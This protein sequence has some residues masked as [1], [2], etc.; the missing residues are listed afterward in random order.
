MLNDLIASNTTQHN[1]LYYAWVRH[2]RNMKHSHTKYWFYDTHDVTL[3]L[4]LT[5]HGHGSN[6]NIFMFNFQVIWEILMWNVKTFGKHKTVDTV[7]PVYSWTWKM[8][9]ALQYTSWIV[10]LNCN[11]R[12]NLKII[13]SM[14]MIMIVGLKCH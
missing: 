1:M 2:G 5:Q 8:Y 14:L 4:T 12:S 11:E 9:A 3:T 7:K 13:L 6:M 10:I